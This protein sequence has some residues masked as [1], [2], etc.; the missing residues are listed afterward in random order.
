[1][2]RC[3][4][5]D[6]RPHP[7]IILSAKFL[8]ATRLTDPN[9]VK[10]RCELVLRISSTCLRTVAKL[11]HNVVAE[12][13]PARSGKTYRLLDR[14]RTALRKAGPSVGRL[15]WIAPTA[16]A[17]AV[18]RER[19]LDGGIEACLSPG[20]TTFDGLT[21]A[22]LSE[23][24]E[25]FWPVDLSAMRRL[26]RR[27]LRKAQKEG[28]LDRF[29]ATGLSAGFVDSV[30]EHFRELKR[31]EIDPA[32]FLKARSPRAR[33]EEH[34]ALGQ[35]YADYQQLLSEHGLADRE[36]R[37]W[38]ARDR[39]AAGGCP[40]LAKLELVVVDGF[41]DFTPTQHDVLGLLANRADDLL[42][43]LPADS[44]TCDS[45]RVDLFA[46]SAHTIDVLRRHHPGLQMHPNELRPS[47]SPAVDYLALNLFGNLRQDAPPS[48]EV[49][50]TLDRLEFVAAAGQHDEMVQIARRI[51]RRLLDATA[52]PG[53]IVV[54]FRSLH[55]VAPR[56][57]EVFTEF[58][59]PFALESSER[60]LH[61]PVVKALL[62]L[63][64]LAEGDWPYRRAIGV[65]TNNRL[66]GIDSASRSSADWLVRDLQIAKGRKELFDRVGALAESASDFGAGLSEHHQRRAATAVIA[67]PALQ[68][69]AGAFDA[70]PE[71]ATL[72]EWSAALSSLGEA[73]GLPPFNERIS[74]A[75]KAEVAHDSRRLQTDRDAWQT[76][77]RQFASLARIDAKL[78]EKPAVL[79]RADALNLLV[80]IASHESLPQY[81]DETGRVRV[82]GAATA[83]TVS[84]KHIYLAGM[85]EQAFPMPESAGRLYSEEEYRE[86]QYAAHPPS[87]AG[88]GNAN[89]EAAVV[90]RSQEEM[91]LFYEVITRAQESVTISYPA[92]DDKAQTMPP[93]P[94][95]TEIERLFKKDSVAT[96]RSPPELS[97]VPTEPPPLSP[98]DFRVLAVDRALNG[99]PELLAE[100][101]YVPRVGA[102]ADAIEAG[103]RIVAD[104]ARRDVFGPAEGILK[105]PAI[106]ERLVRRFGPQHLWSPSQW[107]RYALCPYQ[108]FLLDV[109]GLE[110]LGELSLET[111]FRQR[112]GTLHNV[113]ARFHREWSAEPASVQRD[114]S[115]FTGRLLKIL[116]MEVDAARRFG[117][118]K[119][120]A[121]LDRR[122]I[123]KWA[124]KHFDHWSAYTAAV[125]DMDEPLVP[126][127]F[128][129]R[130]GPSRH[131]GTDREDPKSLNDAFELDIGGEKVRVAGRIDRVDVG[132]DGGQTVFSVVDYKSGKTSTLKSDQITSG[133]RLQL[134][135]Y[136]AAAQALLFNDEAIPVATGYW[137]MDR[138]FDVKGALNVRQGAAEGGGKGDS[139]DDLHGQAIAAVKQFVAH[140]RNGAFPIHSRDESCTSRCEFNTVCRVAHVRAIGKTWPAE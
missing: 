105:S 19:L 29:A 17:A 4:G 103:L 134:S 73:L 112:G 30:V 18:I 138:G 109:L 78:G 52:K 126:T 25:R 2:T 38:I 34:R 106:I 13:G 7:G 77:A 12:V 9:R 23:S 89:E 122:Q 62:S 26:V 110:P 21:D 37:H 60:L 118:D 14:Y 107:E 28:R 54:V 10:F 71:S 136:V 108:F 3:D 69:L 84:A 96:R 27:V 35:L 49:V 57:R 70:L 131:G 102:P 59:I 11:A 55:A 41:T 48:R 43:S 79:T 63:L 113:L 123:A 80:D 100:L 24:Q 15:L 120:L 133:E 45:P 85:S 90:G 99:E 8:G 47:S 83:R 93:S 81:C 50:Q 94:Y 117:I 66:T 115:Q 36:G 129:L 64:R 111:D 56:V 128:E 114:K 72:V 101:F 139:I 104:R 67:L 125:A 91:L 137:S 6:G 32:A 74:A 46:K 97:P 51:K 76:I 87:R 40:S 140:I 39:L 44:S 75:D 58:G 68:R 124:E 132:R 53:D 95:V 33:V 5:F 127:H 20:V 82:L 119:A 1:M 98:T 135:I 130:F 121:E 88:T 16:R 42:I 92:L 86:L 65:L 61:A 22:I 31:R 116:Q